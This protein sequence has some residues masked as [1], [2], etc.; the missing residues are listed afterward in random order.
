MVSLDA[1]PTPK[2]PI[3]YEEESAISS[4]GNSPPVD[5]RFSVLSKMEKMLKT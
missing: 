3:N 5:G 4:V 1:E 2:K